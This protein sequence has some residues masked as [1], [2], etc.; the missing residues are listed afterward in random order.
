[1]TDLQ[2]SINIIKSHKTTKEE[3]NKIYN[4]YLNL[5]HTSPELRKEW[6]RRDREEDKKQKNRQ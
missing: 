4:M 2:K 5:I 3:V 6:E 1:M